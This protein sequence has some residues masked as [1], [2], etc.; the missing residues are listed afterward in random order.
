MVCEM[1][2]EQ[3]REIAQ[4]VFNAYF[5]DIDVVCINVEAGFDHCDDPMFDVTIVYDAEFE[6]LNAAGILNV[7]SEIV[8]KVWGDGKDSP[9]WPYVRMIAKSDI[10]EEDPATV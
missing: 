10:G 2:E 3:V 9:V 8:E 1:N 5:G 6:Q 4:T 7:R